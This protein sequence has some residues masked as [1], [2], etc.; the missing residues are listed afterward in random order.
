ML[1]DNSANK[2]THIICSRKD[3]PP[4]VY[5]YFASKE[6]G[7]LGFLHLI[8][9]GLSAAVLKREELNE[10]LSSPQPLSVV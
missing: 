5:S 4:C 2:D 7:L 10:Q 6:N 8:C 9:D 3:F 1:T